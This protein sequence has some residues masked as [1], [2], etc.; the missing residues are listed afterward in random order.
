MFMFGNFQQLSKVQK[1]QK[2]YYKKIETISPKIIKVKA[3]NVTDVV[4]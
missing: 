4:A 3:E 2:S 1:F